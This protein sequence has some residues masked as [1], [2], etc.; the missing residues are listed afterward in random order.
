MK[1]TMKGIRVL[2]ICLT[3]LGLGVGAWAIITRRDVRA[4]AAVNEQFD[5]AVE[6]EPEEIDPTEAIPTVTLVPEVG[7]AKAEPIEP[8]MDLKRGSFLTDEILLQLDELIT[9]ET[10]DGFWVGA[11]PVVHGDT[12]AFVRI[13]LALESSEERFMFGGPTRLDFPGGS[14]ETFYVHNDIP[15]EEGAACEV[16]EFVGVVPSDEQ[17]DW[18]FTMEDVMYPLPDEGTECEV[19]QKLA[20]ADKNLQDAGITVACSMGEGMTSLEIVSK[21]AGLS[22]AEAQEMIMAVVRGH[23]HGPW[24]FELPMESGNVNPIN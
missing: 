20:E 15:D 11:S 21:P 4:E 3:I 6:S 12:R 7:D 10:I 17:G 9:E 24:Q 16:L 18:R 2:L 19:Y 22:E 5:D 1:N 13:C 23:H 8:G 14:S